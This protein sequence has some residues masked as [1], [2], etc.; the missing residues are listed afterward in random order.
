MVIQKIRFKETDDSFEVTGKKL[1]DL[2][3]GSALPSLSLL[4]PALLLIC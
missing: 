4:L 2:Y 1:S 3:L